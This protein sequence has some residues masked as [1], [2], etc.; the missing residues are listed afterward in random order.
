MVWELFEAYY[1][2]INT[3]AMDERYKKFLE[4]KRSGRKQQARVLADEIISAYRSD[5]DFEFVL[6]VCDA[7]TQKVDHLLW[8]NLILPEILARVADDPRA[9]KALIQTIQNLYSA[10]EEW[11]NLGYITEQD[12]TKRLLMLRP[13]DSWGKAARARVLSRWLA[14]VIHEWPSGVLYGPNGASLEECAEILDAVEELLVL[15][16]S[17][18]LVALCGDV[19]KKTRSYMERL[20]SKGKQPPQTI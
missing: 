17:G 3:L 9:I 18:A 14:Y 15:D 20:E 19:R 8:K 7:N 12:L 10:K 1:N 6:R 4:L 16:A 13:E 11:K 2:Q 5:P